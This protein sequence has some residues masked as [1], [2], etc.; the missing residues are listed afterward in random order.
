MQNRIVFGH[1]S[2]I[3]SAIHKSGKVS[4]KLLV[5]ISLGLSS[6]AK[7]EDIIFSKNVSQEHSSLILNDLKYLEKIGRLENPYLAWL[8]GLNNLNGKS[9][10]EWLRK[11]V[12]VVLAEQD[13]Y[14]KMIKQVKDNQDYPN[15]KINPVD[16]DYK[17]MQPE[18]E[19]IQ[20]N[21]STPPEVDTE[22]ILSFYSSKIT[23]MSNAS[24][25]LYFY[26]KAEGKL[27]ELV[28]QSKLNTHKI[29]ITSPQTGV[30]K[31]G[32]GLFQA[33][34]IINADPNSEANTILRL[35]VFFHEAR[36]G[37]GN[38]KSLGFFHAKCEEHE[39]MVGEN[40]CDRSLNGPYSIEGFILR[41][42]TKNCSTCSEMDKEKLKQKSDDS[43]SRVLLKTI[44][45]RD[46][47]KDPRALAEVKA[48]DAKRAQ[49]SE[50]DFLYLMRSLKTLR[51]TWVPA[52]FYDP[53]PEVLVP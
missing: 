44:A 52:K 28:V 26:G 16:L 33:D 21:F 53:T 42:F 32:R 11:R 29:L 4:A 12:H 45:Y 43:L 6:L 15:P 18:E 34:K 8:M 51:S 31:I 35:A 48:L 46:W 5:V 47:Q 24:S 38:G 19:L 49:M 22:T 50:D 14:F 17:L 20:N 41:E 3:L 27:N 1:V 13:D 39:K 7:A 30:I 37:D 36:H 2:N 10:S 40:A 9:L 25:A 23:V